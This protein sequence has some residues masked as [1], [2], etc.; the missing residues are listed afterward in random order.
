MSVIAL[1]GHFCIQRELFGE[2]VVGTPAEAP[3]EGVAGGDTIRT[4]FTKTI[5]IHP[6]AHVGIGADRA[7]SRRPYFDCRQH[8]HGILV[9]QVTKGP[10]LIHGMAFPLQ[11]HPNQEPL[12]E[13]IHRLEIDQGAHVG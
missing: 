9:A 7:K 4:V 11:H 5:H 13:T 1:I 12:V 8:R 3:G 10:F 2:H 6:E